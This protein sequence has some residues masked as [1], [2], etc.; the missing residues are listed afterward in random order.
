MLLDHR[1]I[2]ILILASL[3]S[4]CGLQ[5]SRSLSNSVTMMGMLDYNSDD[6]G[7]DD[8]AEDD[9]SEDYDANDNDEHNW[10]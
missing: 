3:P 10:K 8:N 7:E 6:D 1:P 9:D 4:S 5:C 2:F